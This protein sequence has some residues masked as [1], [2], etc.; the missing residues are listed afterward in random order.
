MLHGHLLLATGS[1]A[2]ERLHL[3]CIGP[4]ELV[5]RALGAVLLMYVLYVRKST[6]EGHRRHMYCGDL[7][8]QHRLDLIPGLNAFHNCNH[9]IE[10]AL[11]N[12]MFRRTAGISQLYEE[13]IQKILVRSAERIQQ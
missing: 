11:V 10:L 2:L 12:L 1:V 6:S 3:G 8:R 4:G 7:R 5:E 9:E 13:T